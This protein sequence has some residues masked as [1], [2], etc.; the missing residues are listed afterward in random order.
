M[1]P[2]YPELN[3]NE[4]A[5]AYNAIG[6]KQTSRQS[7]QQLEE[8]FL[9]VKEPMATT[10]DNQMA[11]S[12]AQLDQ[13]PQAEINSYALLVIYHY[14]NKSSY[15]E[16][17]LSHVQD[18][19]K[20]IQ[21]TV[22]FGQL[23]AVLTLTKMLEQ[24]KE[25]T[26]A[27]FIE[28]NLIQ[29]FVNLLELNE[30]AQHEIQL[31]QMTFLDLQ[32]TEL[33]ISAQTKQQ[34]LELVC[35]KFQERLIYQDKFSNMY[36]EALRNICYNKQF[37]EQVLDMKI[38]T[39]C[40]ITLSSWFIKR[41][42]II[43]EKDVPKHEAEMVKIL[44]NLIS[45]CFTLIQAV[46]QKD[47]FDEKLTQAIEVIQEMDIFRI[48]QLLCQYDNDAIKFFSFNSDLMKFCATAV[49]RFNTVGRQSNDCLE[50]F[51]FVSALIEKSPIDGLEFLAG[52]C[53][54]QEVLLEMIQNEQFAS[55]IVKKIRSLTKNEFMYK[56]V[57]RLLDALFRQPQLY[58]NYQALDLP[59]HFQNEHEQ[60]LLN[61]QFSEEFFELTLELLQLRPTD[62]LLNCLFQQTQFRINLLPF[63]HQVSTLDLLRNKFWL[64]QTPS[65]MPNPTKNEITALIHLLKLKNV[66]LGGIL[67]F[68]LRL[69][70]RYPHHMKQIMNNGAE[71][72]QN[73][74]FMLEN[75]FGVSTQLEKCEEA[76]V[77]RK[78]KV[79]IQCTQETVVEAL[80][81]V[82]IVGTHEIKGSINVLNFWTRT[83]VSDAAFAEATAKF[84]AQIL[85]NGGK[86]AEK[87]VKGDPALE[88][89]C[90]AK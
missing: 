57:T 67:T 54:E 66:K 51:P 77:Q 26:L 17:I 62:E 49:Y 3:Q 65:E 2:F 61:S 27:V 71:I 12:A 78:M 80:K 58:I 34:L 30:F 50:L 29:Q 72:V 74:N 90:A 39:T 75:L 6:I 45:Y 46:Q 84:V 88:P 89:I 11:L 22:P 87:M 35:R 10:E 36:L 37:A 43:Q 68:A 60:V 63:V 23:Y 81:L 19:V 55:F 24:H 48:F 16:L 44:V 52:C 28:S 31:I 47:V 76:T 64:C 70:S 82:C 56:P 20:V 86:K 21:Y 7:K 15:S 4:L 53:Y 42:N 73:I 79:L 14:T 40:C 33:L 69:F 41:N 85:R 83:C 9:L 59:R 5:E 8:I 25:Q 32:N 1:K 38:L 18:I 13:L